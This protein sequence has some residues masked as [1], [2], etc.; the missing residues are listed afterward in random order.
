MKILIIE[1]ERPTQRMIIDLVKEVEPSAEIVGAIDSVQESVEWLKSNPHPEIILMDI[2]LSDGVSFEI[3]K[4]VPVT[5]M[6]I[7]TTA[8]DEYAIQAFKVNSLDYLLKPV[9]A[10]ELEE[11][12]QKYDN[13]SKKFIQAKN[14]DTNYDELVSAIKNSFP[15]YR[16][17]F[18]IRSDESWFQ[19]PVEDIAYFYSLQKI[20]FAVTFRKREYPV[21]FSLENLKEQLDPDLF[22]KINRQFI[23]NL[24][25]IS[26]VHSWFQGKL[27]LELNPAPEEKPVVGKDKAADFKRWM[28][29]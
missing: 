26:R 24:N 12:F 23:V 6:I 5:S 10:Q 29:R 15:E 20:T 19:V 14:L 3:L 17:R 7:F 4:Q 13:Y 2:Q 21:D 27:V 9:E 25:A 16:K 11:A 18:L 28:D 1:D 22:F 8:F